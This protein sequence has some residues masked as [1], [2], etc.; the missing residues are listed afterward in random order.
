M[1]PLLRGCRKRL[2]KR[3]ALSS[4]LSN[5]ILFANLV[6]QG[7][8]GKDEYLGAAKS[9]DLHKHLLTSQY[10]DQRGK[11][12]NK[13]KKDLKEGKVDLPP[14]FV[15]QTVQISAVLKKIAGGLN[16]QNNDNKRTMNEIRLFSKYRKLRLSGGKV[17]FMTTYNVGAL[18]YI[19]P[20]MHRGAEEEYHRRK[21]QVTYITAKVGVERSGL[22][23]KEDKNTP[24]TYDAKD[25]QIP[26]IS[27]LPAE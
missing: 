18:L 25:Y 8:D 3:K 24:H 19:N 4:A 13:L 12:Q 11:I 20:K 7:A 10:I 23:T 6:I 2:R 26:D 22:T 17:K 9:E 16:I 14:A 21:N 5:N 15:P 27:E 1:K